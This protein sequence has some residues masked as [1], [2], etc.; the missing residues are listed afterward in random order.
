MPFGLTNAPAVFQR[1]M[2]KVLT[3]LNP[4]NGRD[5]VTAYLD[6]ILVFS[7]TLAD[8]LCHLRKVIDRLRSVN[9]KLRPSKCKFVRSEV[10][11]LSHVISPMGLNPIACLTEAVQ[12]FPQPDDCQGIRRF[13]GLASYYRRFIP[14]FA[15]IAQPLHHLT[16]KDV[17]FAWSEECESAFVE[18]KKRLVTPPVLA[19]P[20]FKDDFTLETDASIRG[21]GAVLSQKQEDGKLHPVAYASSALNASEKNYSVTELETLAVVWGITHFHCYLYGN[22]VT[23]LTDHSAVK[24]V[25]EMSNP[26]GKHARWWTKVYGRGVRSV[27]IVYR[28]GRE[29]AS[30]DALSR[31]PCTSAPSQGIA[32]DEVQVSSVASDEDLPMLLQ[33]NPLTGTQRHSNYSGEQLKDPDLR[34]MMDYL[35]GGELPNNLDEAKKL[36]AQESLFTIVDGTLFFIDHRHDSRKRVAVPSH[37]REQLL[38]ENHKGTYSGHFSGLKLYSTLV[39]HWW[40]KGMYT[41]AL[42]F[43]RRC[44]ECAIVTGG[45]RQHRP[46]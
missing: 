33:A 24:S 3:G 6:D 23:V 32:Q 21:L 45:G 30:A 13:L 4:S 27:T 8:H 35:K 15:K 22:A 41:D 11:Y 28:A 36:V 38:R 2:Q 17:P 26:T 16:A 20:N 31:S 46:L 43:C 34:A 19:Y 39:K 42:A 37:L 9:L 29:N 14:G 10:E 7:S 25:L 44:P 40:W 18:L 5:F 12:N 1:L